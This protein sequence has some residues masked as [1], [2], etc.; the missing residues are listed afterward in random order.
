MMG[1]NTGGALLLGGG[2][3]L[4]SSLLDRPLSKWADSHQS[5]RWNT[6]GKTAS[7]MP[8]L[9]AAGTGMLWWGLGGEV[10]SDTAWASIKSAALTLGAETVAKVAVGRSRPEDGMGSTHFSPLSKGG[11]SSFPSI[12]MGVAYSLVTPFAQ[13]YDAPWLYGLAGMTA[14]GRVQERKHFAS[15][16][17]AG[18]L[19]GYG[20]GSLIL[21]QQQERRRQPRITIG[22]DRRIT[23]IWELE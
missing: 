4:A 16:V 11:S 5:S 12:H 1:G 2:M 13:R 22:E 14:F 21:N 3:V 6:L 23:A 20:I 17:V 19:I 7:A 15:D 9:L 8:F 18:G 10:A